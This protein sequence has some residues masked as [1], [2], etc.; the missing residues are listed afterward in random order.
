MQLAYPVQP[1][2]HVAGPRGAIGSASDSRAR[3]ARF[4]TRSAHILADS[5]RAVVV[6]KW[7]K[8][9]SVVMINHSGG[10]RLPRNSLIR[11][12]DRPD[13]TKDVYR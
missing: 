6:S 7:R 2:Y 4:D 1:C 11:L 12:T 10:L 13:R 9:V 8:Y 3:G 5:R